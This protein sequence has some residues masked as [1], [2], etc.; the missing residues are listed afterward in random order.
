M[1]SA[2]F[3]DR[4]T[5]P[6]W[7]SRCSRKT[8]TSSPS[9]GGS[10]NSSS[11]T[12]PSDLNPTSRIT[13]FSDAQDP[14]LDDFALGDRGH[15]ALVHREHAL[16]FLGGIVLVD[17]VFADPDAG[18]GGHWFGRG[19][20][21]HGGRFAFGPVPAAAPGSRWKRARRGSAAGKPYNLSGSPR[22]GK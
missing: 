16:V 15:G 9:R 18:G 1:K 8:S 17:Q 10:L 11:G 4:T 13:A 21:G 22:P 5:A 12:D 2:F 3:F 14:G 6:S 19:R 7:S 20:A